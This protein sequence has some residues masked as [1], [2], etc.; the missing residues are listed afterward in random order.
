MDNGDDAHTELQ[1]W[2]KVALC[3]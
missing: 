3:L 1:R 2:W